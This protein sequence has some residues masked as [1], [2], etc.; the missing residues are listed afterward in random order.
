MSTEP[1]GLPRLYTPEEAADYLKSSE[2]FVRQLIRNKRIKTVRIGRRHLLTEADLV[3]FV[4]ARGGELPPRK[5]AVE[6]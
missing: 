1:T 4:A 6:A 5:K 3:A 2:W